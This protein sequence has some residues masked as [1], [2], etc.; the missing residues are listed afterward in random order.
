MKVRRIERGSSVWGFSG[1]RRE[2]GEGMAALVNVGS[3]EGEEKLPVRDIATLSVAEAFEKSAVRDIGVLPVAELLE[4]LV[5]R[6]MG[7]LS[8]MLNVER[9]LS[10]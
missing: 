2:A 8:V 9:T 6:D 3:A 10:R 7:T 5:V 4:K 1:G